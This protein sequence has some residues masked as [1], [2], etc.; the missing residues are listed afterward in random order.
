MEG[1]VEQRDQVV[2]RSADAPVITHRR[3]RPTGAAPPLPKQ[4]G[5]TGWVWLGLLLAVVVTGCLWLRV[6]PAPLDRL[7]AGITDGVISIRTWWLDAL[8]RQAHTV[9]SR[10]GFAALGLLLVLATAWFR[11]WRH[12]VIWMISIGIAGALLQGLEL[13][14]LRPR[15][16]G[17]RQLASWE[18]YATPSIPSGAIAILAIGVAYMLVVPGEPR[19]WAKVAAAAA[20][21]ITGL[22]RIY[23]GVDHFTDV[24]FGA[25]V[26]VSIP[27]AAFRAFAPND[28]F[29]VSYGRHG[30][31]AHLDVGGRR[32]GAIRAALQDQLGFTVHDIALVGLEGSGGSTPLKLGVTDEEG[33][34]RT[35]FAKLYAKNHVR[36]DRWYKL[37]RTMLYGRLEDETPFTTVRRFVEYEDYTLRMLG[38]YGFPTPAPLGIAEITPEREYLIAMDFFDDAVEIGEAEVDVRVIDEGLALIRR[39]WDIGLAHRDIKPANLMVQRGELKLIDVF[40]V[41]VRPSPWRQAVDVGNMM[42]VLALRSDA[43]TVYE[44]ALRYFTPDELA[45]AFAATRGVAS[46]TQLRQ[47]MK[48]DGR[49]L[50]SEYRSMA[51]AR[52]P[53]AVQRWS[54]RRIAL[55]V[56]SLMVLVLA[57]LTGVALFF[58]TRGTVTTPVCGTEQAMQLMAQAVPSATQLPCVTTLPVGWSVGSAETVNGSSTFEVGVGDGSSHPVTVTLT[59]TC[60]ARVPGTELTPIDGGCVTYRSSVTDQGVPSFEPNGGL[61]LTPRAEVVAEVTADSGLVLCGALA[62]RCP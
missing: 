62:P 9:G 1:T 33:R 45:E 7:D 17:V 49:D 16:F 43:R 48:Q 13:V 55:I 27:L 8:A 15:P 14:S 4:I 59:E 6:D 2:R 39:M 26:G 44:A 35:L 19:L 41:Q 10:V 36:A 56:V 18:G 47:Q 37:G 54:V 12:L 29:P 24:V 40:F 53:I 23:L 31:A 61:S 3:R 5:S 32:G 42:L 46:P 58:P 57:G 52:R 51:P 25:I 34:E 60:P 50:L 38:E 20:I 21:A 11:R 22:L 30:K 28:L